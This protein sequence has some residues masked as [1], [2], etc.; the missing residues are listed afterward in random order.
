MGCASSSPAA[1]TAASAP[2][3]KQPVAAKKTARA[4]PCDH[5]QPRVALWQGLPPVASPPQ[6]RQ[7]NPE[8][9]HPAFVCGVNPLRID[10]ESH[11]TDSAVDFLAADIAAD[12]PRS[13]HSQSLSRSDAILGKRRSTANVLR[14]TS[15]STLSLS[16]SIGAV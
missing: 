15:S 3:R 6:D 10:T 1:A 11:H 7:S 2:Q 8:E 9:H 14:G 12:R 13:A 16:T 4:A 5:G